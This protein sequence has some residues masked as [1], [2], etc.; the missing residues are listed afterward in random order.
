VSVVLLCYPTLDVQDSNGNYRN[1]GTAVSDLSGM[2]TFTWKPDIEGDFKVFAAFAGSE[3]YW[4]ST[5]ETSFVV[6]PAPPAPAEVTFPP[7]NSATYATYSTVAI[8]I[9]IAV[10]GAVMVLILRKR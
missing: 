1:V 10:V 4:P 9:A 8:I 5:A 6:D 7:D 3:S 2:F